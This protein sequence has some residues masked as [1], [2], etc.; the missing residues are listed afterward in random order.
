ML[1]N[2]TYMAAK[3]KVERKWY[4]VDAADKPLAMAVQ[5]RADFAAPTDTGATY[6]RTCPFHSRWMCPHRQ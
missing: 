3:E 1:C 6:H 2:R 4:V 5:P